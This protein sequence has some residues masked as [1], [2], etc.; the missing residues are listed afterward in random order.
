[1]SS[2]VAGRAPVDQLA[3]MPASEGPL[4][5]VVAAGE[6]VP[7]PP[8]VLTA[9]VKGRP[10]LA[11]VPLT[12]LAATDQAISANSWG[13]VAAFSALARSVAVLLAPPAFPGAEIVLPLMATL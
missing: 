2:P 10:G 4:L 9:R 5:V 3:A 7:V 12:T 11:A 6:I 8:A 13:T 1:M